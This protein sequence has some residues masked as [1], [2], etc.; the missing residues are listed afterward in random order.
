MKDRKSDKAFASRLIR[1][2]K[3]HGRHDLPWQQGRAADP[4][5]VWLSEIMLQQTQ[6]ATVIPYYRRFL[7]R[8]PDLASLASA[9]AQEVLA[10]W[11]GL[12]YYARARNLQR[13]AQEVVARHGGRFP[14]RLEDIAALPGI[15]RSTAA[16]IAVFAFGARAAIL[17]GNVKRVLTRVFGIEGWTVMAAHKL[18]LHGNPVV[19]INANYSGSDVPVPVGVGNKSK[20]TFTHLKQ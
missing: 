12:G 9:P 6:V 14:R 13:A 16:A 10:L 15:G 20:A 2:Q 17:D 8:F 18:H 11:S 3:A 1:W 5:R 7:G 4:Y 19:Q